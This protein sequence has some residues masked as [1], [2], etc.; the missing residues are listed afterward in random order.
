MYE[1]RYHLIALGFPSFTVLYLIVEQISGSNL[2]GFSGRPWS[3]FPSV[4]VI[5]QLTII[6]RCWIRTFDH[7]HWAMDG[8][9][10]Q[11]ALYYVPVALAF[12]FN[13]VIYCFLLR[14]L[15]AIMS[16]RMERRI[17]IRIFLYLF[18]FLLTFTSSCLGRL[19]QAVDEDHRPQHVL[20]LLSSI[21]SP[22]LGALNALVYGLNT[23]VRMLFRVEI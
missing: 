13:L 21:F 17:R 11:L 22:L 5:L 10:I 3:V 23:T 16:S 1:S 15:Q 14:R 19:I 4:V 7:G 9:V 6:Y 20:L 8:A 2:V 12:V 18:V